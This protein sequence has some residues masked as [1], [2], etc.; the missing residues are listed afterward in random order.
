MH[1]RDD[2][3]KEKKKYRFNLFEGR[4][5]GFQNRPWIL[6]RKRIGQKRAGPFPIAYIS[7]EENHYLTLTRVRSLRPSLP[8]RG[9]SS[10]KEIEWFFLGSR[11]VYY[12]FSSSRGRGKRDEARVGES[13]KWNDTT[14]R[15]YTRF[16]IRVEGRKNGGEKDRCT[17]WIG[18]MN[19]VGRYS[20]RCRSGGIWN[21]NWIISNPPRR[22]K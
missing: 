13:V 2:G 4:E 14:T 22:E 7:P 18:R 19:S 15:R 17:R 9:T 20:K 8:S 3:L 5:T 1:I 10:R 11:A 12:Y 21:S 6:S 16:K